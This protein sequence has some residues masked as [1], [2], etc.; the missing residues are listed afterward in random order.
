MR[1]APRARFAVSSGSRMTRSG[2]VTAPHT[3]TFRPASL[4]KMLVEENSEPVPAVVGMQILGIERC[5]SGRPSIA[6]SA[7]APSVA[8]TVAAILPTSMAD[9]PPRQTTRPAPAARTNAVAAST[10]FCLGSPQMSAY[11]M[12]SAPT[13][14]RASTTAWASPSSTSA[15]S[16]TST[17]GRS[18]SPSAAASAPTSRTRP[19][20][21]A[22][23]GIPLTANAPMSVATSFQGADLNA[24]AP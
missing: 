10:C 24:A 2:L 14:S 13:R 9:P 12:T 17:A 11:T 1:S 5:G 18:G 20:P 6:K 21:K 23:S 4:V 19:R 15:P 22:T 7:G 8:A 16:V 3:Q